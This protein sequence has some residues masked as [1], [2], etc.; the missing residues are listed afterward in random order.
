[1]LEPHPDDLA[2]SIGGFI[3]NKLKEGYEVYCIT[4]FSK[5]GAITEKRRLENR[6]AL[7]S[8]GIKITFLD[9]PVS[10]KRGYKLHY[11]NIKKKDLDL[12]EKLSKDIKGI[13]DDINPSLILC[14]LGVGNHIDHKIL[15]KI[16]NEKLRKKRKILF[17]EEL[18][19]A[20][21]RN[22]LEERICE[23]KKKNY[24][25]KKYE[26]VDKYISKKLFMV[27]QYRTQYSNFQEIKKEIVE[28]AIK[29]G[30][31]FNRKNNK[32]KYYECL[33]EIKRLIPKIK[34]R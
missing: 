30:K 34:R 25:R 24:L 12:L 17:Y 13:I 29:K 20:N 10:K 4:P 3:L 14:P 26:S 16:C 9:I 19:Y 18:P 11:D 2:L 28:Y 22:Y 1:V 33:W 27:S 6:R 15:F 7:E 23:L 5:E 31:D 8:C 32:N 21:R